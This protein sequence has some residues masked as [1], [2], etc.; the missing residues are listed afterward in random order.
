MGEGLP[1]EIELP[2]ALASAS[3]LSFSAAFEAILVGV[4]LGTVIDARLSPQF[5]W[6]PDSSVVTNALF[7]MFG[8]PAPSGSAV[9]TRGCH[10]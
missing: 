3:T 7:P 10:N 4:G 1:I 6:P 5:I 2:L 8:T 9:L